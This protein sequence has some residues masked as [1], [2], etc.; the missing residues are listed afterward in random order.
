[1]SSSHTEHS[2]ELPAEHPVI[3][4]IRTKLI[5]ELAPEH[6]AIRDVSHRHKGHGGYNSD[7]ASHLVIEISAPAFKELSRVESHRRVYDILSDEL[8]THVHALQI[9]F[10]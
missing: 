8:R 5:S 2:A 10:V 7:G 4:E 6:L 1:M 9:K 3:E